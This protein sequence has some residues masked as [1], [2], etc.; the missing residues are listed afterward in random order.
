MVNGGAQYV[1]L[2][3]DYF[4][5]D[6]IRNHQRRY[7]RSIYEKE[8][9]CRRIH[10][11]DHR[12]DSNRF[13]N[14]R[15]DEKT[16]ARRAAFE[17]GYLGFVVIR[18]GLDIPIGRIMFSVDLIREAYHR[19][20]ELHENRKR[21]EIA[22]DFSA[23]VSH[24]TTAFGIQLEVDC[25]P[26]ITTD[27]ETGVCASAAAWVTLRCLNTSPNNLAPWY[28]LSE[29]TDKANQTLTTQ[30]IMPSRGLN[31]HQL[32]NVFRDAGLDPFLRLYTR[33]SVTERGVEHCRQLTSDIYSL[34]ESGMPFVAC[35]NEGAN[36]REDHAICVVGH[37]LVNPDAV[38]D[39]YPEVSKI[40]DPKGQRDPI[41]YRDFGH[42]NVH[43]I[44]HDSLFGPYM[45]AT[46]TENH[47]AE[48][49]QRYYVGFKMI[50]PFV[51]PEPEMAGASP[52]ETVYALSTLVAP[53]P[54]HVSLDGA[55]AQT[56][57]INLFT[58]NLRYVNQALHANP[59]ITTKDT[60][61]R[62]FL[63]HKETFL[64]YVGETQTKMPYPLLARF[65]RLRLPQWVYVCQMHRFTNPQ[66]FVNGMIVIDATTSNRF[67]NL[68]A[69]QYNHFF[70]ERS[71]IYSLPITEQMTKAA[72]ALQPSDEF[73]PY[74]AFRSA[75]AI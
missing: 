45:L 4:D 38:D 10:I 68:I 15:S 37:T 54:Q 70:F 18:D 36:S 50:D 72:E 62:T 34:Q 21:H 63:M 3:S 6:H 64:Q 49:P 27:T 16:D 39:N 55:E 5:E 53:Y 56:L 65:R 29:I 23:Q 46:I 52:I 7:S 2:E 40:E 48:P 44:I 30:H 13:N 31:I 14:G 58:T 74:R 41:A 12:F 22:I 75:A 1:V 51:P 67:A 71:K 8:T 57:A 43:F 19:Y 60:V 20:Y 35:V 33:D 17:I 61:F 32:N 9:L 11:F 28:S 24:R 25:I 42:Y 59:P 66:R 69:L 47:R 73:V 26:A